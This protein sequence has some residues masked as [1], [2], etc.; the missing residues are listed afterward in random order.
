MVAAME[1]SWIAW[2][3]R[4]GPVLAFPASWVNP[5]A[6]WGICV[7]IKQV[8]ARQQCFLEYFLWL[9]V[10]VCSA[11]EYFLWFGP[12]VCS[13]IVQ[14]WKL[15]VGSTRFVNYAPSVGGICT[16]FLHDRCCYKST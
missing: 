12:T 15:L 10:R 3:L 2:L 13:A 6:A 8:Q 11:N 14:V 16:S 7:F 5:L 9:G 4:H 1:C